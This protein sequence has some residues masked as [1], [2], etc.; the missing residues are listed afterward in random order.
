MVNWVHHGSVTETFSIWVTSAEY[1]NGK[2]YIYYDYPND[3]DP[4]VYVDTDLTDGRPGINKGVAFKD[5]SDGSDCGV[6]RDKQG[7]FHLIYEDWSPINARQH[8]WDSP[9]AGHAISDNGIG[10]FRIL[11]PAVDRRTKP[12][13]EVA[14]YQHPHWRQHPEWQTNLA[15]YDVHEPEQEAFGD[16]AAIG[17]GDR[18]YL[19]GDYDPVDS[20]SMSVGWFTS[21]SLESPFTWCDQ[22][23]KGHPDPDI[24]FAEGRFYLVTQQSTDYVSPGPW[25][26]RVEV[27]VGVDINF[28]NRIDEWT[29]WQEVKETYRQR[30][31]FAKQIDKTAAAIGLGCLPAGH[32]FQFEFRL[33]D[34]TENKSKPLIDR[35]TLSFE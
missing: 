8:S 31:G 29:D 10:N 26:E 33:T 14:Q 19:F 4:H 9:L 25:V 28:D 24:G 15:T 20:D 27:R 34:T 35:V 17:I 18:Y 1:A 13:G 16:W 23:G 11:D 30:K 2:I 6:I 7:R 3:Q 5:P 12:T 21:T 22:I 32:A